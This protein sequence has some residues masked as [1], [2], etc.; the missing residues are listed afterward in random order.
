MRPTLNFWGVSNKALDHHARGL[1]LST[2]DNIHVW[3]QANP[4]APQVTCVRFYAD[5]VSV[6]L[7]PPNGEAVSKRARI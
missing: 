2:F 6:T 5:Q 3:F 4:L 1:T 7:D